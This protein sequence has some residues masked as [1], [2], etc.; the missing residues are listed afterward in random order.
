MVS[1][2][3]TY[4]WR[5][6]L[7]VL[8]GILLTVVLAAAAVP[9]AQQGE[10]QAAN[11]PL[12]LTGPALT[13]DVSAGRHKISPDIY[14][15][16]FADE[17]L[18]RELRLPVRRWGGNATT[19]Y[20]WRNDASNRASDWYFEN[21]PEDNPN[22]ATLPD[23]SSADRF[24]E[25]NR[26][27]GTKTLLTI[28]TIGWTPKSRDYACGFSVRKYGVQQKTDPWRPNCGNGVR[29]DGTTVT[30]NDPTDTSKRITPAFVQ[31]WMRSF[32]DRRGSAPQLQLYM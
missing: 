29:P 21:I 25:Q 14:G 6:S 16:N 10:A 2:H 27:T 12:A 8:L 9:S 30:G 31:D 19:R 17:A 5:R 7:C 4:N 22:P 28:P 3:E 24:V 11:Q 1:M 32:P 13:V 20:N 15:M 26:R 23:G 18:A